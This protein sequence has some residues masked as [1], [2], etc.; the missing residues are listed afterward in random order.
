MT[1]H[2]IQSKVYPGGIECKKFYYRN[3]RSNQGRSLALVIDTKNWKILTPTRVERTEDGTHG[4]DVYCLDNWGNM[5][6]VWLERSNSGKISYSINT[7]E[8][9]AIK[10]LSM[11]LSTAESFEDML[12]IVERYVRIMYLMN[13]MIMSA[14]IPNVRE[15]LD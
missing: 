4:H 13:I 9:T 2:I 14:G 5:M 12:K 8:E 11:L 10:E 7:K 3:N 1:K 15:H 6:I